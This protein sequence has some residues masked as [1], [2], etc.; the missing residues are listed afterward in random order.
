MDIVE[1]QH[2]ACRAL[3]LVDRLKY[4]IVVLGVTEALGHGHSRHS[5]VNS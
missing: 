2:Y 3:I 4:K 1:N 5:T